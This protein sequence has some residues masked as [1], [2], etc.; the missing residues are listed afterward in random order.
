MCIVHLFET[1]TDFLKSHDQLGQ[2]VKCTI[3]IIFKKK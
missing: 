1:H 2:M 3:K